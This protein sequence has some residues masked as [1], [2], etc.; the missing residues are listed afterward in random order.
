MLFDEINIDTIIK[1]EKL[2]VCVSDLGR[3]LSKAAHEFASET[4]ILAKMVG[5]T[6]KEKLFIMGIVEGMYN[7]VVMLAQSSDEHELK[8]IN[9]IDELLEKFNESDK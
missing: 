7:V 8:K 2:Y 9:T 1:D 6:D 4:E 5:L 3:H